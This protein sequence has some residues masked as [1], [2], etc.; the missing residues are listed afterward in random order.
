MIDPAWEDVRA[1]HLAFGS[2]APDAPVPLD[3]DKALRRAAWIEEEA[4]ELRE[5][6]TIAE[7][8][9]AFIDAIYFAL[10]GLVEL[11]VRPGPLW[12]IVQGANMAKLWPD[13]RPRWRE[14]D[15]KVI[16]P[17]GWQDPGPKLAAEID[18]QLDG[19]LAPHPKRHGPACPGHP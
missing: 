16:K 11:G 12:D 6:T 15:G 9:D 19:A 2:P 4:Q 13:G 7:Q 8:A 10:G 17:D 14:G 1:F 5:A 3:R 18:R